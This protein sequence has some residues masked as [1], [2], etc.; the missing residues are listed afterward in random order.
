MFSASASKESS[1]L[2]RRLRSQF[3]APPSGRPCQLI[4]A[5]LALCFIVSGLPRAGAVVVTD[6]FS[7]GNDTANPTW[8]HLDGAVGSPGQS[9]TVTN[10]QYRL[11]DPTTT[12]V[13]SQ[14]PGLETVGFVGS[15]VDPQ[16]TDVR[17]T[18]DFVDFVPPGDASSFFGVAARLNGD[19]A[20][21]NLQ[22]GIQLHGYTYHYE[23]TAASGTGEMVLSILHADGLKDIGSQQ[24]TLDDSK[25]YRFILEAVGNVLHGQVLE[26]D[27]AG[28][29]VAMVAE[30]MRDL[31][32]DPPGD[33]NYDYDPNTPE[34]PFVPYTSGYSGVFGVGFFLGSD[35]D[36][37]IDNFRTESVGSLPGDFDNNQVVNGADLAQW[38]GD[39]G[40]DGGSDAD[41]DMDS[42][43]DDFLIWQQN[44]AAAA[45]PA[46][47]A[48]PEPGTLGLGF[49][50]VVLLLTQ[51][52]VG[53]EG[54]N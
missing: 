44:S 21:P 6:D 30:K 26:L 20:Q 3:F 37:T 53:T 31:D 36:F 13:G 39:F 16:F 52:R 11:L 19:N 54:V 51:F 10:G 1:N 17:V 12:T 25:D 9:W 47:T 5:G 46:L 42:D 4:S 45:M 29:V 40:V 48:V 14:F 34:G 28:Q 43:G 18:T 33:D 38:H 49:A 32:A 23:G 2:H 7:D 24:V 50:A 15:Y 8:H 22:T 41:D 35:A 27:G